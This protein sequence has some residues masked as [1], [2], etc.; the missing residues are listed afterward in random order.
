MERSRRETSRR[1]Y[2]LSFRRSCR[3]LKSSSLLVSMNHDSPDS[4]SQAELADGPDKLD[5]SNLAEMHEPETPR[6]PPQSDRSSDSIEPERAASD[7]RS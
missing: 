2:D 3:R 6:R 1:R 4:R 5:L 7:G